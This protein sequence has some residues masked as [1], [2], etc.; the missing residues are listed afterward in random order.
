MSGKEKVVAP[1]KL[2]SSR[3]IL[4]SAL[5]ADTKTFLR[6]W[7]VTISAAKNLDN[8]RKE[9]IFGKASRSRV[10]DILKIFR[11]RYLSSEAVIH[12]L[13]ILA[14]SDFPAEALDCILYF[15]SAQS[16][17]LL[18][19]TVTEA[20]VARRNKGLLEVGPTY[21]RSVLTD[22]LKEGHMVSQWSEETIERVA[23]G[24]LATLRDFGILQG[25]VNKTI[26]PTHLPKEAFAFIAFY[27]WQLQPSGKILLNNIEWQLFFLSPQLVEHYLIEAHQFHLLEYHAAGSVIRIAF[28]AQTL[29]GYARALTERTY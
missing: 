28:P 22:W 10:E 1:K 6:Y 19:D 16:D 14:K 26:A 24:L 11:R 29:E 2:Y 20:L 8:I 27:L 23:Q 7:D 4:A 15:F 17:L 21:I 13:V 3:I 12:S 25:A 18:H 5:L 9:N